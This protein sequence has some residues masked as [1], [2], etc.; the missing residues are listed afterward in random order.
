MFRYDSPI[1]EALNKIADLILLGFVWFIMCIPIVTIGAAT[2]AAYYA[3]F[4]QLSD[5]DG[6]VLK[7]FFKSFKENF[8]QST[9]LFLIVFIVIMFA[10]INLNLL[11]NVLTD[12]N[13]ILRILMIVAQMLLLFESTILFLFGCSLLSKIEFTT[14]NLIVSALM[15]GNKHIFTSILNILI[16]LVIAY[17]VLVIPLLSI[18]SGGM[19]LLLTAGL[20][21]RILVKYRPEVFEKVMY[22]DTTFRVQMEEIEEINETIDSEE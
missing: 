6:Y 1:F 9:I 8:K 20:M 12:T 18:A 16:I 4:A 21:K 3:A 15:L 2:T 14:K 10:V 5:K 13:N 22:D 11:N 7:K 17:A 19:Y